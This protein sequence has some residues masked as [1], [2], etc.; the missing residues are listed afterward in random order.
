MIKHFSHRCLWLPSVVN[1]RVRNSV[2]RIID[3]G[4][5]RADT[6]GFQ[7]S[8]A[9]GAEGSDIHGA[10]SV[11]FCFQFG[12]RRVLLSAATGVSASGNVVQRQFADRFETFR[13]SGI[14]CRKRW[15][16]NTYDCRADRNKKP[17]GAD[18]NQ[19]QFLWHS[20]S[21]IVISGKS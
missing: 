9:A 8:H 10:D 13:Q 16:A 12:D 4:R 18:G 20:D 11:S 15:Q 7:L 2:G 21:P 1:P 6:F 17:D 19:K 14:G 5:H 3:H